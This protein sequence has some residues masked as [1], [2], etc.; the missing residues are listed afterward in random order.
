MSSIFLNLCSNMN[1]NPRKIRTQITPYS[2]PH[3]SM[4]LAFEK[5]CQHCISIMS[6]CKVEENWEL[7]PLLSH[8]TTDCYYIP[9]LTVEQPKSASS[10]DHFL[11]LRKA[12]LKDAPH[13]RL[14]RPRL[15]LG[16][17]QHSWTYRHRNLS[18]DSWWGAGVRGEQ[19]KAAYWTP[20]FLRS[21]KS[22]WN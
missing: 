18:T 13:K 22:F 10:L 21:N 3:T 2:L 9:L 12:F 11:L 5:H 6:F 17:A 1:R 7:W 16:N 8:D 14:L 19:G 15:F 20:V 4:R